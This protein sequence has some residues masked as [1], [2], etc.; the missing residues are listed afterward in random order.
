MFDFIPDIWVDDLSIEKTDTC[1][2]LG[3][4]SDKVVLFLYETGF[5]HKGLN[6]LIEP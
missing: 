3:I 4:P 2:I 5:R 1:K 6:F